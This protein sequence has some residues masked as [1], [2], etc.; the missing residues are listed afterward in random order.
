MIDKIK[1]NW[2]SISGLEECQL[3]VIKR[4]LRLS[5]L[6]ASAERSM[7]EAFLTEKEIGPKITDSKA[8]ARARSAVG[9]TKTRYQYEFETLAGLLGVINARISL[10][11]Q[12]ELQAQ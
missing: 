7:A 5:E 11:S 6:I 1:G 4:Q 9:G 3:D 10:L 12:R 8:R 2:T